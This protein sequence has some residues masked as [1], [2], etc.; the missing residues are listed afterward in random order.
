MEKG[1]IFFLFP[2]EYMLYDLCSGQYK[3]HYLDDAISK[4]HTVIMALIDSYR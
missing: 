2:E 3:L 1:N 4:Q